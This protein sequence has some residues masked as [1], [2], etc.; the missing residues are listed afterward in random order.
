MIKKK[1]KR[2]KFFEEKKYHFCEV[3]EIYNWIYL[4]YTSVSATCKTTIILLDGKRVK[5]Q[6]NLFDQFSHFFRDLWY[7][8]DWDFTMFWLLFSL[9]SL[10][11]S[12]LNCVFSSSRLTLLRL[13]DFPNSTHLW[14]AATCDCRFNAPTRQIK[15]HYDRILQPVR[16]GMQV[17]KVAFAQS[18]EA[19][20][21][22]HKASFW[23]TTSQTSGASRES[24]DGWKRWTSTRPECQKFSWAIGCISRLS[25]KSPPSQRRVTRVDIKCRALRYRRY[26]TL[27]YASRSVSWRE[28]RFIATAWRGYG[29]R[30]EVSFFVFLVACLSWY[31][32]SESSNSLIG[33]M[34]QSS[35]NSETNLKA[36]QNLLFS[37]FFFF[38]STV[39]SLQEL[40]CRTIVR[41]M[42]SVYS[43]DTLPLPNPVKSHLKSYAL[44][45]TTSAICPNNNILVNTAK[46]ITCK[47]H[48]NNKFSAKNHCS[49][50]WSRGCG[51]S[52]IGDNLAHI[53]RARLERALSRVGIFQ[54][55]HKKPDSNKLPYENKTEHQMTAA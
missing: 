24:T 14:F 43:I 52:C 40:C 18:Y 9:F 31:F 21:E 36:H 23:C 34:K 38:I 39:L 20:R 32:T 3:K 7:I 28:W 35:E 11:L 10:S 45:T 1:I 51:S 8:S 54:L 4:F 55:K 13:F 15:N 47:S 19:I 33:V 16:S 30:I 6:V 25:D 46:N 17:D 37:L 48:H 49:V 12:L 5:L 53:T 42:R 26:A 41:R 2:Q 27:T 22:A 29:G 50:S 44:T